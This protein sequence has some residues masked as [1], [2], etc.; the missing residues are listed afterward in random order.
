M[1]DLIDRLTTTVRR[2]LGALGFNSPNIYVLEALFRTAYLASLKTEEGRYIRGSITFADPRHPEQNPPFTRRADYPSFTRFQHKK[3]LTVESLVKLSRAIDKWSGSIAVFGTT[4]ANL[5][6]WGVV[7]QFVQLNVG[8]HRETDGGF[9]APGIVTTNID[10]VGDL[11]VYHGHIFLG[12]LRGQTLVERED[13]VLRT[14]FIFN[15]V[16]PYLFPVANAVSRFLGL[17]DTADDY[18]AQIFENWARIVSRLCIGLRRLGTGGAFLITPQPRYRSL[19][20]TYKMAYSRLGDAM[21]LRVLDDEYARHVLDLV[22]FR[23][24]SNVPS[25]HVLEIHLSETDA[26]DRESEVTGAVKLVTS[27]AAID[28]LVLLTPQ[29]EVVGFGA[30]IKAARSVRTV[31][32]GR[33]FA[34]RGTRATKIDVARFG[35][36][37]GS[38]LRYCRV[39]PAAIG[40]VVSQDGHVRII[41]SINGSLTLW[42]NVKLLDHRDYSRQT[43][44][45]AKTRVA[46]YRRGKR[47]HGFKLGYTDTPKTMADLLA[48]EA[49]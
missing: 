14:G 20:V 12:S 11:S 35:T 15:R 24:Q 16:M 48:V 38:M 41:A 31:Y 1:A 22:N 29:L 13:D 39:D 34:R 25:S 6:A 28:G 46:A 44:R 47:H 27:F 26:E 33:S 8:I 42:E 32:E 49:P 10:G 19:E 9:T 17:E 30:K 2:R 36:R 45:G 18:A 37:H 40:I 21:C 7:D 5:I 23:E 4:K 3:A 43:V